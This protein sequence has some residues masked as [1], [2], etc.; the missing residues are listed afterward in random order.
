VRVSR[1]PPKKRAASGS[2]PD[3]PLDVVRCIAD[4]AATECRPRIKVLEFDLAAAQGGRDGCERAFISRTVNSV[5]SLLRGVMKFGQMPLL[6]KKG[7][8]DDDDHGVGDADD[9]EEHAACDGHSPRVS[10]F[11]E[12]LALS[13]SVGGSGMHV[14]NHLVLVDG[15]LYQ[16]WAALVVV[17][18]EEEEDSDDEA[19][20][21]HR[22]R[23]EE[24]GAVRFD[25]PRSTCWAEAADLGDWAVLVGRNETVAVRAG[26][27]QGLSGSCVYFIDSKL[28]GVACAFD[29]RSGR[30][31]TVGGDMLREACSS[32]ARP[33][34][35]VWFLPSLK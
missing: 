19:I 13:E 12:P 23:I 18:P 29:L 4:R 5:I 33:A 7:G 22:H 31:E 30:A 25:P 34:A 3:P 32:M 16:I 9:A 28:D 10:I 15:E 2:V 6:G 1:A 20:M 14:E 26:D 35:P 24:A 8:R 11:A 17:Q 27:V 21:M